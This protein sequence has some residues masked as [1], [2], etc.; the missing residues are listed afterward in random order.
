MAHCPITTCT[1]RY[2]KLPECVN[3]DCSVS[4]PPNEYKL[5]EMV[6]TV[7][8]TEACSSEMVQALD[9]HLLSPRLFKVNNRWQRRRAA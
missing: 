4:A 6:S 3:K 2:G 9:R 5:H 8:V 1:E 7:T